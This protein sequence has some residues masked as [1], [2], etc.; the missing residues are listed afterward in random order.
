MSYTKI[1]FADKQQGTV[2]ENI[3]EQEIWF[4]D[5][6]EIK[7]KFGF[8]IDALNQ[9]D[10][11]VTSELQ[12]SL[13]N[14]QPAGIANRFFIIDAFGNISIDSSIINDSLTSSLFKTWS[15]DKLLAS[16]ID[17]TELDAAIA[18]LVD[19][20]PETLDTLKEL[21][22]S[23]GDDPNFATTTATALGNRLRFDIANQGLSTTQ[24]ANAIANLNLYN[25]FYTKTEIT[26]LLATKQQLIEVK[27]Q[28]LLVKTA[29]KTNLLIL[30]DNDLFSYQTAD[31]YVVGVILDASNLTLPDD[32]DN[33]NKIKLQYDG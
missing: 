27:I 8:L 30:E 26:N 7:S 25:F 29:G 10:I 3:H 20:S 11:L 21:A 17:Q 4:S 22:T 14:V 9:R 12:K 19:S 15:I 5:V 31:R 23:L 16:F 18:N 1:I 13:K 6:N 24:I 32:L 2:P 33:I 28:G